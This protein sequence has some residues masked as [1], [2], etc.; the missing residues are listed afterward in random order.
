MRPWS[1]SNDKLEIIG[2]YAFT[3]CLSLTGIKLPS[4]K[5]LRFRAFWK[6]PALVDA[7]FGNKLESIGEDVFYKCSSLQRIT[8]PLKNGLIDYDDTFRFCKNLM[9]LDLVDEEALQLTIHSLLWEEWKNDMNA[10]LL[11]IDQTLPNAPAGDVTAKGE[12][13]FVIRRWIRNV[14]RKI[15]DYKSQHL[16][17]LK[18]AGR[19]LQLV[20]PHDIV[21]NSVAPFLTLPHHTFDGEEEVENV[22]IDG[23]FD[24]SYSSKVDSYEE[25]EGYVRSEGEATDTGEEGQQEGVNI[26]ERKKRRRTEINGDDVDGG[27]HEHLPT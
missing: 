5:T 26:E 23:Y 6:C 17:L 18:E 9:H 13:A 15:I 16:C 10:E 8:L 4:A 7:K 27:N 24:E 3:K 20:L 19:M 25:E 2:E 22:C 21:I 11:S 14:L 12:K 1:I